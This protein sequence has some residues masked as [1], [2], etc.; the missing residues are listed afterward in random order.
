MSPDISG[1]SAVWTFCAHL[2][3]FVA[4]MGTGNQVTLRPGQ[5]IND[6]SNESREHDQYHPQDSVIHTPVLGIFRHPHQQSD[7]ESNDREDDESDESHAAT[8]GE[9]AS[10][11]IAMLKCEVGEKRG[12]KY[13]AYSQYESRVHFDLLEKS[14]SQ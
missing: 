4:A 2:H 7:I 14:I 13:S 5:D 10:C 11:I 3:P 9:T 6:Q 1:I 12:C 8:G